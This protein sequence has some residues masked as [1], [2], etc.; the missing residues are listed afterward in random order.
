MPL[1]TPAPPSTDPHFTLTGC[2]PTPGL[3]AVLYDL[4]GVLLDSIR[5][6]AA[7]ISEVTEAALGRKPTDAAVV[8]VL[9]MPPATALHALGVTDPHTALYRHFDTAYARHAH[10]ATVNPD[11]VTVLRQFHEA[12]IRQ[13]IVTLQRRHR[14]HLLDLSTIAPLIDTV[15]CYDDAPP[16]PAPAPIWR[17]LTALAAPG[18]QT[19]YV[20][21]TTTDIAAARAAGIR[22]AGATWGYHSAALLRHAGADILLDHPSQIRFLTGAAPTHAHPSVP[23]QDGHR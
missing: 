13:G 21:D 9:A 2:G 18:F 22:V 23:I 17:A 12:G 14:L 20:G 15:V 19:W 10:L 16:K 4:D 8:D 6:M 5:L 7:V 1:A 11:A 3:R